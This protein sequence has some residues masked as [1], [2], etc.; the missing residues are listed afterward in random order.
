MEVSELVAKQQGPALLRRPVDS[1]LLPAPRSGS[2]PE[3]VLPKARTSGRLAG[4]PSL[5]LVNSSC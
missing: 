1:V 5:L 4:I 2:V 3:A